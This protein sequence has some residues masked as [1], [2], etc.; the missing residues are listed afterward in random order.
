MHVVWQLT[1]A[2]AGHRLTAISD[3]I[4]Q[5]LLHPSALTLG[6]PQMLLPACL[7]AKL[8][9]QMRC[10]LNQGIKLHL[11]LYMPGIKKISL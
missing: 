8:S 1:A 4:N 7:E 10:T 6:I 3:N 2:L 5:Q 9:T 11:G